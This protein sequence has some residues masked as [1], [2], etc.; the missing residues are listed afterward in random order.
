METLLS[1]QFIF[2]PNYWIQNEKYS[3]QWDNKLKELLD[4]YDFEYIDEYKSNLGPYTLWTASIP[5]CCMMPINKKT[6]EH[7]NFRASRLTICR[8]IKKYDNDTKGKPILK[9]IQEINDF[10]EYK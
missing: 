7:A 4:L 2:R 6:S 5:F 1:L 10:A 8:A 9:H 3:E